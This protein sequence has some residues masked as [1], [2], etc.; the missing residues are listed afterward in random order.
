MSI[1]SRLCMYVR[2]DTMLP[3]LHLPPS[4]PIAQALTIFFPGC[5]RIC[6]FSTCCFISYEERSYRSISLRV[7]YRFGLSASL[8]RAGERERARENE[9]PI[10]VERKITILFFTKGFIIFSLVKLKLILSLVLI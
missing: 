3:R 6:S 2:T 5:K 1:C 4:S 7:T 10:V 8:G 9:W